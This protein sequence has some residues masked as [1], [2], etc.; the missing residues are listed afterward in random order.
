M[1]PAEHPIS[2]DST[3]GVAS[4]VLDAGPKIKSRHYSGA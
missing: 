3:G 2:K 4:F 1:Q